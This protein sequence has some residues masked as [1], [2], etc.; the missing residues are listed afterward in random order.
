VER[1]LP[2][3][4]G[5]NGIPEET[6][7]I[8]KIRATAAASKA[9]EAETISSPVP[10]E[11]A[12][13]DNK[14]NVAT[15]VL[16]SVG[17]TA[18]NAVYSVGA[19][20]AAA[21]AMVTGS[22]L[23]KSA[24]DTAADAGLSSQ[25]VAR[26]KAMEK[27]AADEIKSTEEKATRDIAAIF[28]K[29]RKPM[30]STDGGLSGAD[31]KG[32]AAS[33]GLGASAV[34]KIGEIEKD[35]EE[36]IT[37][38]RNAVKTA[39]GDIYKKEGISLPSPPSASNST[40]VVA[41]TATTAS[42]A[43]PEAATKSASIS[44]PAAA[45]GVAAAA[46]AAAGMGAAGVKKVSALEEKS[47]SKISAVDAK[48]T[49]DIAAIYKTEGC[50]MP[51][52][53][54]QAATVGAATVGAASIA[55]AA[56]LNPL[57]VN[58]VAAVER[59]AADEITIIETEKAEELATIYKKNGVKVEKS[60]LAEDSASRGAIETSAGAAAAAGL[61][62]ASVKKIAAVEAAASAKKLA[63]DSKAKSEISLLSKQISSSKLSEADVATK[64]TK[65]AE[66]EKKVIKD[67]GAIDTKAV[68]DVEGIYKKGGVKVDSTKNLALIAGATAVGVVGVAAF[69]SSQPTES[70]DA[71]AI[72][73]STTG[74]TDA[75]STVGAKT[76]IA[77][78]IESAPRMNGVGAAAGAAAA[79]GL[80]ASAVASVA[81][82]EDAT[83]KKIVDV[84][85][86][87]ADDIAAIYTAEGATMSTRPTTI[88]ATA[89][90]AAGAAVVAG[91]SLDAVK[92]VAAIEHKAD[93]EVAAIDKAADKEMASV[94][95]K[96]GAK[97]PA[98]SWKGFSG[99]RAATVTATGAAACA[100][101]GAATIQKIAA[102]E[103]NANEQDAAADENAITKVSAVYKAAGVEMKTSEGLFATNRRI[104]TTAT[105][106]GA[107]AG[108][109][110]LDVKKIA[111]I[112]EEATNDICNR[113]ADATKEIS[114]LY[115]EDGSDVKKSAWNG[116]AAQ[117]IATFGTMGAAAAAASEALAAKRG[118]GGEERTYVSRDENDPDEGNILSDLLY[119]IH[120]AIYDVG[121]SV[122]ATGNAVTGGDFEGPEE[123]D[124]RYSGP[125][126]AVKTS[127]CCA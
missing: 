60:A 35:A 120:M 23:D 64:K 39:I 38:T 104:T 106:A 56:G 89:V 8:N 94:Y 25:G 81:A 69:A 113:D 3:L 63:L 114:A 54:T 52:D 108:L 101:L 109:A 13:D 66:I 9:P 50:T 125:R 90:G 48:A 105:A 100:G 84:D 21:G 46:A 62:S 75:A 116:F 70:S 76:N 121:A 36:E 22:T 82:I 7:G 93:T 1:R 71:V 2:C 117:R 37:A 110:T 30:P 74:V 4:C 73:A 111:D 55:A 79:A 20:V 16:T 72:Q 34:K 122:A 5:N 119:G 78:G 96:D 14:G 44:T 61:G 53:S 126:G 103:S 98:S 40:P 85:Q 67:I 43:T 97:M 32:K 107:A 10:V 124:E 65:I 33:A 6:Y 12:I 57:A 17:D 83:A 92:K 80:S 59:K 77:D 115:Q 95:K 31:Y 99:S 58:K 41:S 91:L 42:V 49:K 118:L 19:A 127:L 86:K 102:I 15:D 68:S 26:V 47:K 88:G 27:D 112:E 45:I 18:H 87:A 51:M 11:E 29:G 28:K 24:A 123:Y